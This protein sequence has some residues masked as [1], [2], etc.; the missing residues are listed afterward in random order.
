MRRAVGM[1][2]GLSCLI[3]L[4]LVPSAQQARPATPSYDARCASCHGAA[5]TGESGP[6]ILAYM[7]YHTDA[8]ASAQVHAK[9]PTLQIPD[10]EVK[11][12]LADVRLITG[13]NPSM[14]TGGYTGRRGGGAGLAAGAGAAGA[15][16][17]A[18]GGRAGGR[19]RGAGAPPAAG[20]AVPAPT[21]APAP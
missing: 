4:A 17:A 18:R 15:A 7:R 6:S 3:V 21:L 11:Q 10:A 8:E 5:M 13:T 2:L 20:N 1:F 16:P 14:A 9:H 12:V 19:G